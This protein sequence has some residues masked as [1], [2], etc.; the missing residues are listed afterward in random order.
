MLEGAFRHIIFLL[1]DIAATNYMY[2]HYYTEWLAGYTVIHKCTSRS[3]CLIT[4]PF[5]DVKEDKLSWDNCS[6]NNNL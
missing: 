3:V 1:S 5:A 4:I 6:C 2:G